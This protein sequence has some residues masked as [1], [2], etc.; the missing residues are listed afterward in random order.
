M[1]RHCSRLCKGRRSPLAQQCSQ[2]H[3]PGSVLGRELLTGLTARASGRFVQSP[4]TFIHMRFVRDA[5]RIDI[6]MLA[7]VAAPSTQRALRHQ[8]PSH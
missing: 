7:Q 1:L 6:E 5:G 8:L 2:Q 3:P 4:K